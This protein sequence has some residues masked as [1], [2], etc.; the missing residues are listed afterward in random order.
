MRNLGWNYLEQG[1]SVHVTMILEGRKADNVASSIAKFC[2][3]HLRA[4]MDLAWSE[5]FG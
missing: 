4:L 1:V 3:C 5:R 2:C